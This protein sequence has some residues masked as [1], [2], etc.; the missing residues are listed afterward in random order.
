M[1]WMKRIGGL[2]LNK[3]VVWLGPGLLISSYLFGHKKNLQLEFCASA[4]QLTIGHHLS[5]LLVEDSCF[6]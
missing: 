6:L 2:L 3:C 5:I 4:I 1:D